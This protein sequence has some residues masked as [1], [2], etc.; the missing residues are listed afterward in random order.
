[1]QSLK[2]KS[3]IS[4]N[5]ILRDRDLRP[6]RP[7]LQETGLETL[8][9]ETKSRVFITLCYCRIWNLTGSDLNIS[10]IC[11]GGADAEQTYLE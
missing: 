5:E 4:E 7:R 11:G 9:I 10:M 8:E 6:S 1:M 2:A 3:S